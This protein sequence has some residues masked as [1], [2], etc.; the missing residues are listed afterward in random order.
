M[1]IGRT[2]IYYAVALAGLPLSIW[3][4]T[5]QVRL[6]ALPA[7]FPPSDAVYPVEVQGAA[8]ASPAEVR[9]LVEGFRPGSDILLVDA[10]GA[11]SRAA[12]PR[13]F[14]SL[15]LA[16]TL[17]SGLIFW[18]VSAFV[19][20]PRASN[21]A[22]RDFF[23][24]TFLYGI[25]ILVGGV[26]FPGEIGTQYRIGGILQIGV[27]AALPA[28]FVHLTLVFPRR[29]ALMDRAP[30]IPWALAVTAGALIVWQTLAFLRHAER[31]DPISFAA[32]SRPQ[33]LA[34]IA[35]VLQ[36]AV[37]F[38]VL[39]A[40]AQRLELT[41]ERAQVKWLLWGF[42]VGVT[43][44]VFL[45][46]LLQLIGVDP[47]FGA[48]FDR[49][50]ELAIP[51]AFIGSVVRHQFLDIDI[52]IR[53]SVIYAFLAIVLV[54]ISVATA[55]LLGGRIESLPGPWRVAP[56][57]AVG[58]A[59]GL[60]FRP[61]RSWIGLW[62]DRTFFKISHGHGEA[63]AGLRP[64]IEAAS[65]ER[66][67][68]VAVD[69]FLAAVFRS[70]VHAAAALD[71]DAIIVEG[72]GPR[73][74]IHAAMRGVVG[75]PGVTALPNATSLPEVEDPAFP[76]PLSAAGIVLAAPLRAGDDALGGIFLG[77][78]GTERRY[79]QPDLDL[80]RD[81]ALD[82]GRAI[83]KIRLVNRAAEEALA[84]RRSEELNRMKGEF[85]SRVAHDLRT[86][87]A[88]IGWSADNLL[89]GIPGA[90]TD[91]Q[92]EYLRSVKASAAHLGRLVANLLEVSRI[93]QGRSELEIARTDLAS[94][95]EQALMTVR[96]LA[97]V[98][99]V[100]IR[101]AVDP[102]A[103]SI[104]G[105]HAKL[106]EVAINLLDN[107]V[108]FAPPGSPVEVEIPA[109]EGPS[110]TLSIRDHGAGFQGVDPE[111]LFSQYRQGAPSGHGG[112]H[113]FGLGLYIVRTYVERMGGAVRA[114][115]HPGGGAIFTCS[116]E[117]DGS[118]EST[119]GTNG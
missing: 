28:F 108:R 30:W 85:L 26:H 67:V 111:T 53:R 47:P 115:E 105:D 18:G 15:L 2:W 74:A 8:A 35:L 58:I 61:L 34:D 46:T 114:R 55:V 104:R 64:M 106:V 3:A 80:V 76:A 33:R 69:G 5:G 7:G 23:W 50:M 32:M 88:S 13:A 79:V 81:V 90:V 78:R 87:I 63:L 48:E 84:R 42:A 83:Q 22:A 109:A 75:A 20:A 82:A 101:L 57:I 93:E 29:R 60:A 116:F 40:G 73:D 36:V 11:E 112:S 12:L 92:A 56:P 14:S 27:L 107:A 77:K 99:Q 91:R 118:A 72:L 51:I 39:F 31:P 9:Y 54:S 37:G 110:Q 103:R 62:V 70:N 44:Y 117:V 71:G 25:G 24:C 49:V 41:R 94:V 6:A 95:M 21:P 19:F 65:S 4:F 102:A 59:A 10:T 119:G 66:A 100:E 16:V 52:I 113:G 43:P 38:A 45:R 89:D 68:L 1:K 17:A 98:K 97:E 86:P 96:P